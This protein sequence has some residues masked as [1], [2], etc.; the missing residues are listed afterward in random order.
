[1]KKHPFHLH[2]GKKGSAVLVR[3]LTGVD[4]NRISNLTHDGTLTVE[5]AG[6]PD[7]GTINSQLVSFL[8]TSLKIKVSQ[9]EIV[10]GSNNRDKLISILDIDPEKLQG[11][12]SSLL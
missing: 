7:D 3:V 2:D 4:R 5:L 10:A 1:M 12:I 9:I 6:Q 11:K 8:S